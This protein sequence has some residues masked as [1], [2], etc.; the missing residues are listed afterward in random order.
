MTTGLGC[1][2]ACFHAGRGSTRQRGD[3]RT[4]SSALT[5]TLPHHGMR[6]GLHKRRCVPITAKTQHARLRDGPVQ[7]SALWEAAEAL[8]AEL[9]FN[10]GAARKR[11]QADAIAARRTRREVLRD[12]GW[13]ETH[14]ARRPPPWP[15]TQCLAGGGTES[16]GLPGK[17]NGGG[18]VVH[19]SPALREQ[20]R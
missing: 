16:S 7:C 9:E 17:N 14:R 4:S 6:Q 10:E 20:H 8:P 1:R 15:L 5:P 12:R 18:E 19:A 13:R 11:V 3:M 2:G